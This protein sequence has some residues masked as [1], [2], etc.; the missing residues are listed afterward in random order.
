MTDSHG[1]GSIPPENLSTPPAGLYDAAIMGSVAALDD[2]LKQ[3]WK[4]AL[5]GHLK[6]LKQLFELILEL[7]SEQD[8]EKCTPRHLAVLSYGT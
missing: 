6:F 5:T 4:A 1:T 8:L 3:Y 7:A 2:L